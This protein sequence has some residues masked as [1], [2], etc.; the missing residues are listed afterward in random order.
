MSI[1]GLGGWQWPRDWWLR[2]R[3]VL[4]ALVLCR[5]VLL[6]CTLPPLEGCDEYQHIAY[7]V[8]I[9]E[10]GQNPILNESF[11]PDSLLRAMARL[12]M[13]D[14]LAETI[15]AKGLC[16]YAAFWS[17]RI[18]A[19]YQPPGEPMRLYEAQHGPLYYRLAAPLFTM[20]G[21]VADLRLSVAVLRLVNVLFLAGAVW[22]ALGAV[23]RI[24]SNPRDAAL[25][26]LL[27][28]LQPFFLKSNTRVCNDALGVFLGT[29]VIVCCLS[30]EG[31]RLWLG[32]AFLGLLLGLAVLAKAVNLGLLPLAVL[33]G[34]ALA[35]RG[36]IRWVQGVQTS[37]LLGVVFFA[38]TGSY[39]YFNLTHFGL[40]TPM[41]EAVMN[42]Q[43]GRG[44][45]DLLAAAGQINW[46][47]YLARLWFAATVWYGEWSFL[48]PTWPLQ[49]TYELLTALA[50]LGALTLWAR[51]ARQR[52]PVAVW[53]LAVCV[54]LCLFLTAALAYHSVHSQLAMGVPM[55][56]P[57]Y[58]GVALP[59]LLVLVYS[60]G[61]AW[62][63]RRL[64][65]TLP[66][67]LAA[68]FLATELHGLF[69]I[70]MET[71]T[72]HP[73]GRVALGR[74]AS[75][76]PAFLGTATLFA[77][78]AGV[79]LLTTLAVVLQIVGLRRLSSIS[80]TANNQIPVSQNRA[81]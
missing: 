27:I 1:P 49:R 67:L 68:V 2:Y 48:P 57:S 19:P 75:L 32:S 10:K 63:G 14:K 34:P 81:A 8:H 18:A 58:L 76:Q 24:C 35:V 71:Y 64:K 4:I 55:T 74:L 38:V 20:A 7:I 62:P 50:L 54:G 60:C 52:L 9:V 65:M 43:A 39:F 79:L 13:P 28:A 61:A 42:R 12:P 6:L 45:R 16:G 77:S 33:C 17:D 56:Q 44:L 47:I 23:G 37:V 26:G 21:G 46:P 66:W 3:V 78:T 72:C 31:R 73:F 51:Q 36:K 22:L 69:V 80:P 5:G 53:P 59:W 29:A 40:P 30:F 25:L 41:Q 70:N 15:P 11:V